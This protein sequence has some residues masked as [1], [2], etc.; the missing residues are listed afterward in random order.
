MDTKYYDGTKLLSLKD[1][2][3]KTPEFVICCGN[4]TAG[5]TVY[6]NRLMV[7]KWLKKHEQFALVYR[8]KYSAPSLADAFWGDIGTLFFPNHK[9]E[10][11]VQ[12]GGSYVELYLD[13]ELCGYGLC[14]NSR[15]R[16]KE[17]SHL[18]NKVEYM[19]LDEFQ[20]ED[21]KYC[22]DEIRKFRSIHES[23]ARGNGKQ[24]RFVQTFLVGN[25][26]SLLN[27]YFVAF[28]LSEKI[29]RNTKFLKGRG[30][31]LEQTLNKSASEAQRNSSFNSAFVDQRYLD[32]SSQNVYLDD[33]TT[34]I[35]KLTGDNRYLLTIIYNGNEYCIRCYEEQGIMYCG[36]NVDKTWN[37]RISITTED[38]RPNYVMLKNNEKVISYLK[39]FFNQGCFRFKDLQCKEAVIHMLAY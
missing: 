6:F 35:E 11:K 2:N 29:Q 31:V 37:Y 36:K 9:F 23:V 18:F 20:S 1:I 10:G 39:Y 32:Y 3:G 19:L 34:F 17:L 33:N 16:I 14:L 28:G 5:K 7:N 25:C 8:F 26:I 22:A 4:R 24:V 30:L 13:D 12:E 15:S 38:M 21:N 27:P